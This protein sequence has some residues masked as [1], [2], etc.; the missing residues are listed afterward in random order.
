[1]I[2]R[3]TLKRGEPL[4]QEQIERLDA[5]KDRPIVFD[6]DSPELT[7]ET[8]AAFKRAAAERNA[9]LAA[10]SEKRAAQ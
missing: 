8:Y 7:P 4:T 5:L 9:R 2:V 10:L 6:E 1:M 3:S